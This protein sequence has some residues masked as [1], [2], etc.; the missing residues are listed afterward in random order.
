ML[1]TTVMFAA[2]G[3]RAAALRLYKE[4]LEGVSSDS[5]YCREVR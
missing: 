2:S 5:E 4:Y 1:T 3:D